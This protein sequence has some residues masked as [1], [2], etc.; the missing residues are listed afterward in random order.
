MTRA[1]CKFKNVPVVQ[2]QLRTRIA[3]PEGAL[4]EHAKI[5]QEMLKVRSKHT[6]KQRKK[7]NIQ[8]RNMILKEVTLLYKRGDCQLVH[9]FLNNSY[10]MICTCMGICL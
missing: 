3:K 4:Q 5:E 1:A 9:D 8:N 7:D 10:C 2:V 6:P